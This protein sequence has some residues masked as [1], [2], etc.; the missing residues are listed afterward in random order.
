MEKN[1]GGKRE[2]SGRKKGVKKNKLLFGYKYTEEEYNELEKTFE[3]YKK[4][5]GL[6]STKAIKKIIL[7]KKKKKVIDFL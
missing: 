6:T 1:R 5:N 2:G 4:R 3:E 7:E